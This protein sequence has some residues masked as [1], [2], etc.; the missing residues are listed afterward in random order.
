MRA[1]RHDEAVPDG[2]TEGDVSLKQVVMGCSL[3]SSARPLRL[4][5]S[6][7]AEASVTRWVTLRSLAR[8]P[9]TSLLLNPAFVPFLL[10]FLG[11]GVAGAYARR[12]MIRRFG[13]D[14]TREAAG[15]CLLLFAG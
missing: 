11:I 14:L 8:R 5:T 2:A 7:A 4:D 12:L 3:A 9:P 10:F 1:R 13:L 15:V 6:G